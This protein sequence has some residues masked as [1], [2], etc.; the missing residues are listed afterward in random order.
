MKI[1]RLFRYFLFV[2]EEKETFAYPLGKRP[3][4]THPTHAG[5]ADKLKA[6][7]STPHLKGPSTLQGT[8][9]FLIWYKRTHFLS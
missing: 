9:T 3:Q 4:T 8:I 1:Y 7:L 5:A 6:I 2:F